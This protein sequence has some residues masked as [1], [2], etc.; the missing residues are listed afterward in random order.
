MSGMTKRIY[1]ESRK[2]LTRGWYA[3]NLPDDSP[4]SETD[5]FVIDQGIEIGRRAHLL[6]PGGVL[7]E[8]TGN[9]SHPGTL[10]SKN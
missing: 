6:Y 1:L 7:V 10:F 4:L 5:Q 2:C 9:R 8:W 3:R